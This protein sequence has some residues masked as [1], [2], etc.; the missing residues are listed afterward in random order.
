MRKSTEKK[1]AKPKQPSII[2]KYIAEREKVFEQ[3]KQNKKYL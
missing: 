3:E 2:A 1:T